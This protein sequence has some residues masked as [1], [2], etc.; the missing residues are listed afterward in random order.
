M[1]TQSDR[2]LVTGIIVNDYPNIRKGLLKQVRAMLHDWQINGLDRA[3]EKY[4]LLY[5]LDNRES[6]ENE[7]VDF[8]S[9]VRGKLEHLRYVR[10]YRIELLNK[11]DKEECIRKRVVYKKNEL[12]TIHKDQFYKYYHQFELIS[13]RDSGMPTILG[14]GKTDWM[15]FRRAF[16]ELKSQKKYSELELNIFKNKEY[17]LG[18]YGNLKKFYESA[19]DIGIKFYY[20]VICIFDADIEDINNI[21]KCASSGYLD[22]GNSVYSF[23]LPKP[24]FRNEKKFSIELYYK[25]DDLLKEDSNKRRLYLNSEFDKETGIHTKDKN[26]IYGVRARDGKKNDNWKSVLKS[27][28]KVIDNS[29]C[30][31]RDGK[32]KNI[33]ISKKD[34]A[35]KILKKTKPFDKVDFS[36][37]IGM[38]DIIEKICL[39]HDY[40]TK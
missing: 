11:R 12:Q 24:N 34:F 16:C 39:N 21:H 9:V 32:F 22:H 37:F 17:G 35:Q 26:I 25:D 28:L 29:V 33:A 18:G 20:P 2:Q 19:N 4:S 31:E 13:I 7:N 30:I 27:D 1:R 36:S 23:V 14:E 5:D 6:G 8:K 38:F 15:H 40:S 3:Q 10:N